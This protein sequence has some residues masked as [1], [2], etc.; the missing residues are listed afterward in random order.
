[1]KATPACTSCAWRCRWAA[2]LLP[3]AIAM[4]G[5]AFVRLAGVDAERR[6]LREQVGAVHVDE[7]VADHVLHGLVA[8]DRT[9][10]LLAIL[11]VLVRHVEH[12]VRGAH[13]GGR[14]QHRGL[15]GRRR[16]RRPPATL[17]ADEVLGRHGHVVEGHRVQRVAGDVRD[18]VARRCRRPRVDEQHRDA[19]GP[20]RRSCAPRHRKRS[21]DGANPT[22]NFVPCTTKSLPLPLRRARDRAGPERPVA[23]ED[24]EADDAF[25]APRSPAAS[26]CRCASVPAA[27]DG[28][29][30]DR[31]RVE[32]RARYQ[33]APHLLVDRVEVEEAAARPP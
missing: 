32:M 27:E 24:R 6:L 17:R 13:D 18:R 33:E 15:R 3:N 31:D 20:G 9:A 12:R 14:L 21:A 22:S 19:V 10:E 7:D 5:F 25:A 11:R 16:Q 30:R 23:L 2:A 1:M 29:A 28:L 26:A 4:R 8:A